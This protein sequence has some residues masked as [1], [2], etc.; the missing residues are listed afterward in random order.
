MLFGSGLTTL[1]ALRFILALLGANASNTFASFVN[2][3][4]APFVTPF[5]GLFNYDHAA[6]GFVSFQG[7][8]LVAILAYSLLTAAL[9]RLATITRY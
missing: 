5:Y 6:V 1:L 3:F 8:T 2:G 7:Y 4:T 9:A